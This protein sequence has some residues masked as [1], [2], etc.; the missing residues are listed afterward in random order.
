MPIFLSSCSSWQASSLSSC[1]STS[2]SPPR[3]SPTQI[4]GTSPTPALWES[5][6]SLSSSGPSSS[7]ET[8]VSHPPL[9]Q[10]LRCWQCHRLVLEHLPDQMLDLSRQA[11]HQTLGQR[12]R[13]ILPQRLFRGS[14]SD[15]R[16]VHLS[17]G[18]LLQQAWSMLRA[19]VLLWLFLQ[20]GQDR[21]L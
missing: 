17:P 6:T 11:H 8:H 16:A 18:H 3:E 19:K 9:S 12:R 15:R 1:S 14:H 13:R 5:S 20:P 4:S 7:S 2:P 21:C 10:L